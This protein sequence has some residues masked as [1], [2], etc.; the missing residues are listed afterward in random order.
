MGNGTFREIDETAFDDERQLSTAHLKRVAENALYCEEERWYTAT[1]AWPLVGKTAQSYGALKPLV[2]AAADWRCVGPFPVYCSQPTEAAKIHIAYTVSTHSVQVY[3]TTE[4]HLFDETNA[5]TLSTGSGTQ[6]LQVCPLR[7]GINQVWIVIKGALGSATSVTGAA[8]SSGTLGDAGVTQF[9]ST[10]T[11]FQYITGVLIDGQSPVRDDTVTELVADQIPRSMLCR[12]TEYPTGST[13]SFTRGTLGSIAIRSLHLEFSNTVPLDQEWPWAR[14]Y[15]LPS[16]LAASTALHS[17]S[18]AAHKRRMPAGSWG[19]EPPFVVPLSGSAFNFSG[20]YLAG[21][22]FAASYAT[23]WEDLI[24][25]DQESAG[26]ESEKLLVCFCVRF[27]GYPLDAP[28]FPIDV[29]FRATVDD[30]STS[31]NQV[32]PYT[33]QSESTGNTS[34][35]LSLEEQDRILLGLIESSETGSERVAQETMSRTPVSVARSVWPEIAFEIDVSTLT[36]GEWTI[37]L[38]AQGD[39]GPWVMGPALIQRTA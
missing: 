33:G 14:W 32:I 18:G 31:V 29:D 26:N 15:Q 38:E 28:S 13:V 6:E 9:G 20:F 25:S 36:A 12:P 37:T 4:T 3:A 19:A 39:C 11:G 30:G 23:V 16:A 8:V 1:A 10:S 17:A 22:N 21:E 5:E 2:V 27:P 35:L 24:Y 7:K 34:R